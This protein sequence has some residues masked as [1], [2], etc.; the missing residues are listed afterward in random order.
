[1]S[2]LQDTL[3]TFAGGALVGSGTVQRV[4]H[5]DAGQ[6]VVVVTETP[7]H[8]IDHTWPDQPGD[9]G[10]CGDAVVT[11]CVMAAVGPTGE[12]IIGHDIPVKRGEAGWSWHVGHC[13]AQASAPEVG[14]VVDL[15]VDAER[16]RALSAAHTA[17]HLAAFAMNRVAAELWRKEAPRDSLGAPNLDQLAMQR[18]VMDVTG[19]TD[20][21][22]LGKSLRKKGFDAVAFA[23]QLPKVEESV[24]QLLAAW[25]A[26]GAHVLVDDGGDRR[27]TGRRQWVCELPE[28]RAAL[29]CGGTHLHRLDEF[30]SVEVTYE[31]QPDNGGVVMRTVP[32]LVP[33]VCP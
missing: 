32:T 10:T 21:Y 23:E 2:D 33:C 17:C 7:F 27:L 25:V 31:L 22:R 19:S 18:S 20:E 6:A 1:M 11:D 15:G 26:T 24:N 3:V 12:L 13:M 4:E 14:D 5:S 29:P 28:G 30:D 8:P 16:R 9:T